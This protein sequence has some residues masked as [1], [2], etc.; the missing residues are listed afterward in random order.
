MD[1][2]EILFIVNENEQMLFDGTS[3]KSEIPG[4]IKSYYSASAL[5]SSLVR[6][7]GFKLPKSIPQEKIEVQSEIRMFDE[8][9]LDPDTNFEITSSVIELENS[10]DNY[11]EAY[12]TE[13]ATLEKHYGNIAKKNTHIDFIFPSFLSYSAIYAFELLDKKND[14]FI[15]FD[16]D[17]AYAVLFKNGEYIASRSISSLQY[18]AGK[19]GFSIEDT[20]KFLTTKGVN[21]ELYTPEEFLYMDKIK[22]ELQNIVERISHSIAHKR[23][24]FG[25]EHNTIDRIYLDFEGADIPGFLE[26]FS[27]Y[28]YKDVDKNKLDIFKDVEVGQKHLAL[29]ALYALGMAQNKYTAPNL[30]IYEKKPHF[31]T[32][33]I[34]HFSIVLAC[35]IIVASIYP[36]YAM[37]TLH[38]LETRTLKLKNDLYEMNKATKELQ[39]KIVNAKK[40]KLELKN[41]KSSIGAHIDSFSYGFEALEEFDENTAV[42]QKMMKDVNIAMKKYRLSSKHI[43]CDS[44]NS[45][46]VQIIT[47]NRARDRIAEFMKE[48]LLKGYKHVQTKKVERNKG[49]Y[50]SFVEIYP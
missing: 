40:E 20:R 48:L 9:G 8:A 46:N 7:H 47:I 35:A 16:D 34:G 32:T 14:L 36:I 42:R 15:Y 43:S 1:I 33:N 50:E 26:L 41:K 17:E 6:T 30:T 23:N 13:E 11:I 37:I 21:S 5:C 22:E 2:N 49:Y 19:L 18:I 12:A 27:N 45:M 44:N 10:N 29:S 4:D 28:G 25:L 24:V 38:Q 3:F 31:L 39:E